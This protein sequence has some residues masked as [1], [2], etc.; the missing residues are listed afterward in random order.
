MQIVK[1]PCPVSEFECAEM[2]AKPAVGA[3]ILIERAMQE[4]GLNRKEV[5]H[6]VG[7]SVATLSRWVTGA[8]APAR[9]QARLMQVLGLGVG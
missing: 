7:V 2:R 6:A 4:R 8:R 5:A 9:H 1:L 3:G